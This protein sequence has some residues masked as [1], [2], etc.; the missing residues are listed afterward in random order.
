MILIYR[1]G[2]I[3]PNPVIT[4]NVFNVGETG[5]FGMTL[6]PNFATNGYLYASYTIPLTT[7]AGT[8]QPYAQ[9]SRFTVVNGVANVSSEKVPPRGIQVQ[10]QDGSGGNYDHAG[11]DVQVGP[12]GKLW[13]SVGDDDPSNGNAQTL[14][15]IYGK[16]IRFNLDGTIPGDNPFSISPAPSRTSMPGVAEPVPL[17]VPAEWPGDDGGHR[18]E[19][20]GGDG[21]RSSRA[22]TTDG[23]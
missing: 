1:N 13:W 15:N 19:L 11:N 3:L 2:A 7:S 6:D 16:I 21:R 4:L 18:V 8:N 23:R 10:L 20:L 17:H 22:V 14:T 12:D 5:L 9:L